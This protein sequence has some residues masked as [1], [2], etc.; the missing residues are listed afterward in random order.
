[1]RLLVSLLAALLSVPLTASGDV[2][3]ACV[4]RAGRLRI[5]T[6]TKDSPRRAPWCPPGSRV[7]SWNVQGPQGPPGEPGMDGEPGPA[8]PPGPTLHVFDVNGRDV[9]VLAGEERTRSA[10]W[11]FV[12][13]IGEV[14]A[15]RAVGE[16]REAPVYFEDAE[17]AG[18][19]NVDA[20]LA[21]IAVVSQ[22]QVRYFVGDTREAPRRLAVAYSQDALLRCEP[23]GSRS[24]VSATEITAE[25]LG[26]PWPGP[27]YVGLPPD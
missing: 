13:G 23:A 22:T 4:D 27:L 19:A 24:G 10:L 15:S 17:C 12:P 6:S 5:I 25:D 8:G 3:N 11:V 20:N 26:L 21:G 9:G 16:V 18:P 1:M 2:I 7:L 14:E